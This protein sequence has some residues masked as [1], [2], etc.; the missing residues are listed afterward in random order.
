[1]SF[2]YASGFP[3]P[4][5]CYCNSFLNSI[6]STEPFTSQLTSGTTGPHH[7]EAGRSL[8]IETSEKGAKPHDLESLVLSGKSSIGQATIHATKCVSIVPYCAIL[9]VGCSQCNILGHRRMGHFMEGFL[10]KQT[11]LSRPEKI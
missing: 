5:F 3:V 8:G 2:V 11:H 7:P 4:A 1:M 10:E 9:I 6:S